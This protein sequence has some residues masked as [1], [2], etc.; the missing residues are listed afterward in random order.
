MS[1]S[2]KREINARHLLS[3]KQI[4][5]NMNIALARMDWREKNGNLD[6]RSFWADTFELEQDQTA[7]SFVVCSTVSLC[8][9]R[10]L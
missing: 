2:T 5:R 10:G 4:C 6:D 1:S 8:R 3:S 9:T 7:V